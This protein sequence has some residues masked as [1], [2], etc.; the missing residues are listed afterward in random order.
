VGAAKGSVVDEVTPQIQA[1]SA[2]LPEMPS[3]MITERVGWE[4]G[5]TVFFKRVQQLRQ[6]LKPG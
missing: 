1:L 6:L 3:T 5:K 2:E 4:R